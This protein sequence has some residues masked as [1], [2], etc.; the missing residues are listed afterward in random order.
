MPTRVA[1][2]SSLN[3]SALYEIANNCTSQVTISFVCF[4]P[5]M[6]IAC[7]HKKTRIRKSGLFIYGCLFSYQFSNGINTFSS[8]DNTMNTN[9]FAGL[10]A[11]AFFDTRCSEPAGSYQYSPALKVFGCSP[12]T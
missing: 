5:S 1:V 3:L 9:N 4:K 11:L 10:V 7:G 2:N 8:G 6:L 12:F